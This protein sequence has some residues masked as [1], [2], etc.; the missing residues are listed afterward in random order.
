MAV[1]LTEMMKAGEKL[2][3]RTLEAVCRYHNARDSSAPEADVEF[4]RIAA[5]AL[6]RTVREYQLRAQGSSEI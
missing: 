2:L 3:Q 4:L 6:L 5:E 1:D